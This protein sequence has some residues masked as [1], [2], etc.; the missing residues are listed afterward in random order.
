MGRRHLIKGRVAARHQPMKQIID[1]L[2]DEHC[3]IEKLLLVLDRELS[4]FNRA[5][6]PDY[7][8]VQSV[9]EYFQDYPDSCHHP[10]EDMIFE[11]LKVRDPVTAASI[12]DLQAE[13][14][15]GSKRLARVARTVEGVLADRE[16]LRDTVDAI[17]RDFIDQE[18]RHMAMEERVLFPAAMRVLLPQD[19]AAI[20]AKLAAGTDPL[21]TAL[22]AKYRALRH[23]ILQWE[24]EAESERTQR[25]AGS[26]AAH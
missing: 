2:R 17:I 10:K 18:R 3:N 26:A 19:W 12:G 21:D 7:H 13:H 1:I 6:R 23:L 25:A 14:G 9:I 15:K 5:E 24:Q 8:V 4:V 22:E 20:R 16:I 11:K